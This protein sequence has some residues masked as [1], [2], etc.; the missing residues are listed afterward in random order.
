MAILNSIR[1]LL[2]QIPPL[3]NFEYADTTTNHHMAAMEISFRRDSKLLLFLK[4]LAPFLYPHKMVQKY[5][6]IQNVIALGP[7]L[8][9]EQ[10]SIVC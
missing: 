7:L 1:G 9:K 2:F 5:A 3:S 6:F 4:F 10:E 8:G